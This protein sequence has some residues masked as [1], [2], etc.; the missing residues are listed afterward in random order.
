MNWGPKSPLP[1]SLR[2]LLTDLFVGKDVQA[3]IASI[4]QAVMQAARPRILLAPLQI[5]LGVQLHHHLLHGF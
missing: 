5:G 1:T 4:G 2:V 3:K